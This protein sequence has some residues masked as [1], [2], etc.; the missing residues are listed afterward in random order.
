MSKHTSQIKHILREN[1]DLKAQLMADEKLIEQIGKV[2]VLI[3]D[4]LKDHQKIMFC[5]NGGSAADAQHLA[6]ELSGKFMLDRPPIHAEAL[7]V[8]SSFLTA[9]SNDMGYTRAF[10]R[11]VEGKGV[12]GD[13]LMAISTSGNSENI[14]C[15]AQTAQKKGIKVIGLTGE[16]GGGLIDYCDL[17]LRV[18]SSH[19]ARIQECHILI[20]HIICQIVEESLFGS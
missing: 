6:A 16:K 20:G 11:A 1:M 18:P 8:N 14:I 4:A 15:A 13:I 19:T 9:A 12:S 17:V 3:T 2:C 7:H 5:G 10:A